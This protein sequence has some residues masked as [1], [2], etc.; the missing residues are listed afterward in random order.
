MAVEPII[1][2]VS[3]LPLL[4]LAY[5]I[6]SLVSKLYVWGRVSMCIL[7]CFI[8]VVVVDGEEVYA[9]ILCGLVKA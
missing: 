1:P 8:V 9:S 2:F 6:I 4:F 5:F 3:A 7:R